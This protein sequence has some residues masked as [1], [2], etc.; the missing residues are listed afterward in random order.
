MD[1]RD[2]E[3]IK[4]ALRNYQEELTHYLIENEGYEPDDAELLISY[5]IDF[6]DEVDNAFLAYLRGDRVM[7][8]I[9]GDI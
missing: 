6:V 4:R 8:L 5:L 3:A 9:D 7:C 2:V 1:E